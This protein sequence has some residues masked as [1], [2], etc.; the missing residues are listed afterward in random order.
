[1]KRFLAWVI[2]LGLAA[3]VPATWWLDEANTPIPQRPQVL[4]SLVGLAIT[5][6]AYL[7]GMSVSAKVREPTRR[8]AVLLVGFGWRIVVAVV[9][10]LGLFE[11]VAAAIELNAPA[12]ARELIRHSYWYWVAGFYLVALVVSSTIVVLTDASRQ[13]AP[14]PVAPGPTRS[15]HGA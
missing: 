15:S 13:A 4:L 2:G 11:P 12:V 6:V 10:S 5:L 1:M 3:V 9:L 14:D 8:V 7:P